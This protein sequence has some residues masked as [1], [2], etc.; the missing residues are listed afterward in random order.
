MG[1]MSTCYCIYPSDYLNDLQGKRFD[2]LKTYPE[3]QALCEKIKK[4]IV[5]K[6]NE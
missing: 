3:F 5:T 6:T 4:L 2:A 1:D